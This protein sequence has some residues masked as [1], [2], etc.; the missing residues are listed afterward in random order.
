MVY[1]FVRSRKVD[2]GCDDRLE[3]MIRRLLKEIDGILT[4]MTET[5]LMSGLI[6]TREEKIRA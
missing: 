6:E 2:D 1:L 4:H 3:M 5:A